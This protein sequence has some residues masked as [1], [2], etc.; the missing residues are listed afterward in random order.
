MTSDM[1]VSPPVP[2]PPGKPGQWLVLTSLRDPTNQ[3]TALPV[4]ACFPF[5]E[6][7]G[8]IWEQNSGFQ[9]KAG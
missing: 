8:S 7:D 2:D 4:R 3:K 1:G 9:S 5:R 6:E